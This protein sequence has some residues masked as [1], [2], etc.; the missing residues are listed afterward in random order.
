[1]LRSEHLLYRITTPD[2]KP[3]LIAPDAPF[4]LDLAGELAAIYQ[5]AAG[6][7]MTRQELEELTGA[8]IRGSCDVKIAAGLNKLL[9]DRTEFTAAQSADYPALRRK[10]FLASGK[11]LNSGITDPEKLRTC[12]ALD[13]LYGDLPD[14]EKI[15]AFEAV[16]PEKLLHRYNLAQAQGLLFFAKSMTVTIRNAAPGELRKLLK[17]VKFFRLLAHFTIPAKN[18]LQMEISGPFSLFDATSKY[19][20]QLANLLPAIALLPKWELKAQVNIKNRELTLKLSHKNGLVSH[21]R[22]LASYIPEEIRLFHKLFNAK[23]DTW[24][25]VGDT[26]FIDAGNQEVIFP[27]LSFHSTTGELIHAEL[28]H[29][30]HAGQLERRLTLLAENPDL[31]LI[32]GIDRSLVKSEEE[33]EKL[34]ESRPHIRRRCWLFRDFPGVSTVVNLLKRLFPEND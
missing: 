12:A 4:L 3:R 14:F 30:W 19:A 20:L 27:D 23:Q 11:M 25:I 33:F 26:P 5:S 32:L 31:P 6:G 21:Y 10:S 24:Q 15:A 18:Q 13:D 1:M 34:F 28:F 17:T 29:R 2:V 8:L 22:Q 9:L 16:S 7:N